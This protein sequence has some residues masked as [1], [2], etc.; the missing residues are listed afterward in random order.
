[1]GKPLQQTIQSISI[2]NIYWKHREAQG[3]NFS[4]LW[5]HRKV[6]T[7]SY[8]VFTSPSGQHRNNARDIGLESLESVE[9][10]KYNPYSP[11]ISPP[12]HPSIKRHCYQI[13]PMTKISQIIAM[14]QIHL[15]STTRKSLFV[16][17]LYKTWNCHLQHLPMSQDTGALIFNGWI[18]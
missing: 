10:G 3:T 4:H 16:S 17:A 15:K 9:A 14:L 13:S 8:H 18:N 7:F 5:A 6:T 12:Q 1:M 11:S 2:D